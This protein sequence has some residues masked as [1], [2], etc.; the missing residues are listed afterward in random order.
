MD[1]KLVVAQFGVDWLKQ[2]WI[3][4]RLKFDEELSLGSIAGLR[5]N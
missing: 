2:S 3:E 1:R 5:V 4:L